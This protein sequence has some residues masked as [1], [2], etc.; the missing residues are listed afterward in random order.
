M[1][2]LVLLGSPREDGNTDIVIS[3]ILEALKEKC[4]CTIEMVRIPDMDIAGCNECLACLDAAKPP[5]CSIND[6][7]TGLYKKIIKADLTVFATP[8][9]CWGVPAQMKA[10]F[11]RLYACFRFE[12]DEHRCVLS[13]KRF[14]FVVTAAG[15]KNDGADLCVSMYKRFIEFA[16]AENAGVLQAVLLGEPRETRTNR[17]LLSRARAFAGK[18]AQ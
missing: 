8:V 5:K 12:P 15:G 4:D 3:E 14:A 1:N 17:K 2:V 6:D 11:D 7:M 18:L 9:F 16:R 13:G 10:V